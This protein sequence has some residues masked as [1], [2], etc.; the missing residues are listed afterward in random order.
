M[1]VISFEEIFRYPQLEASRNLTIDGAICQTQSPQIKNENEASQLKA[2]HTLIFSVQFCR[3]SMT[4]L[5]ITK[6]KSD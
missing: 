3:S 5:L 2:S 4:K 6:L 1:F